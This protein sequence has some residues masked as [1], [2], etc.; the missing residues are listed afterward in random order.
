MFRD[1]RQQIFNNPLK[2]SDSSVAKINHHMTIRV[3]N[4]TALLKFLISIPSIQSL[5]YHERLFLSRHNVR[6]LIFL[7][8][9]E[10]EQTCFSES[11]QVICVI[12]IV[13]C[14]DFVAVF[15]FFSKTKRQMLIM[16]LPNMF[17]V[18]NFFSKQNK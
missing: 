14:I 10:L 5:P 11:W 12:I 6:P 3:N 7:N 16:K 4:I 8:L 1:N 17:M 13:L 15:F 9:L 18:L 2:F